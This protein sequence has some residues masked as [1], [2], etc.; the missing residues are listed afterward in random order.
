MRS[1]RGSWSLSEREFSVFKIDCIVFFGE[2][3]F[4]IDVESLFGVHSR[5][6]T[7]PV[8]QVSG[9]RDSSCQRVIYLIDVYGEEKKSSRRNQNVRRETRKA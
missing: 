3:I 1:H 8:R 5:A 9:L 6:R 2:S 4:V 7:H